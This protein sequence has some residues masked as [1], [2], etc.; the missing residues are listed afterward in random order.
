MMDLCST[1]PTWSRHKDLVDLLAET[2]SENTQ[3]CGSALSKLSVIVSAKLGA[4]DVVLYRGKRV[5]WW[6]IFFHA[7]LQQTVEYLWALV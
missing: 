1:C 4:N 2:F 7:F 5:L 3:S 6:Q